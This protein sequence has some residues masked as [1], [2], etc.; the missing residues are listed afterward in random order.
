MPPH[1]TRERTRSSVGHRPGPLCPSPRRCRIAHPSSPVLL[2]PVWSCRSPKAG[3]KWDGAARNLP[4]PRCSAA[5]S[6]GLSSRQRLGSR[7]VLTSGF[8]ASKAREV[9]YFYFLT[10]AR[11]GCLLRGLISGVS[12]LEKKII[13]PPPS[14]CPEVSRTPSDVTHCSGEVLF[15]SGEGTRSFDVTGTLCDAIGFSQS[16]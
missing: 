14:C 9:F 10:V 6:T 7:G 13:I 11:T 3:G 5:L 12:F 16:I 15:G 8:K 1:E 4:L 2:L